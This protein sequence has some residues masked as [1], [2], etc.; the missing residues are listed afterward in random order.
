M[1]GKVIDYVDTQAFIDEMPDEVLFA[2]L[3]ESFYELQTMVENVSAHDV[4]HN[5]VL[6]LQR[7]AAESIAKISPQDLQ[8]SNEC[9][10]SNPSNCFHKD[11]ELDNLKHCKRVIDMMLYVI[12]TSEYSKKVDLELE[13]V[14][15]TA[16]LSEPQKVFH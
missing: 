16:G 11:V 5:A 7:L 15:F 3:H 1:T 14:R 8:L 10:G 9:L 6:Y 4:I 2:E 12:N 13:F